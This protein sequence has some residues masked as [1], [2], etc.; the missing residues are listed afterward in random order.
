MKRKAN[1]F[2]YLFSLFFFFCS[3]ISF[4]VHLIPIRS[5]F[6]ALHTCS[7][8]IIKHNEIWSFIIFCSSVCMECGFFSSTLH[9]YRHFFVVVVEIINKSTV[10]SD[11]RT[12]TFINATAS[13]ADDT[14]CFRHLVFF[15]LQ[16]IVR[17]A[18]L[19]IYTIHAMCTF[20]VE[21]GSKLLKRQQLESPIISA[22]VFRY[23]KKK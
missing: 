21:R 12:I 18:F 22:R 20:M 9:F 6:F 11:Y 7:C 17:I 5:L 15:S 1:Q 23:L 3:A 10:S 8:N 2:F 4:S 13:S 16:F 19:F 14:L